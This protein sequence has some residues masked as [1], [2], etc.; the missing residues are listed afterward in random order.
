[1]ARVRLACVSDAADYAVA[2]GATYVNGYLNFIVKN[3]LQSPI[4]ATVQVF[5]LM[6]ASK[7]MRFDVPANGG[8]DL[9]G[10]FNDWNLCYSLQSFQ[11]QSCVDDTIVLVPDL[12]YDV[13]RNLTGEEIRSVRPLLQKFSYKGNRDSAGSAG[14]PDFLAMAHHPT[15]SMFATTDITNLTGALSA[16]MQL[17]NWA[18]YYASLFAGVRG[19]TRWKWL[20]VGMTTDLYT[21]YMRAHRSLTGLADTNPNSFN[22][23]LPVITGWDGSNH[24]AIQPIPIRTAIEVEMPSYAAWQRFHMPRYVQTA[25]GSSGAAGDIDYFYIQP[26]ANTSVSVIGYNAYGPDVSV[27]AFRRTPMIHR[28]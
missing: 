21:P 18:G 1:M 14:A 20:N 4:S 2:S 8:W 3:K 12:E 11:D 27:F 13:T 15:T 19:S 9:T 10:T 5:V 25:V 23:A 22:T 16:K 24:H 17:F 6:R 28:Y 7:D 26:G